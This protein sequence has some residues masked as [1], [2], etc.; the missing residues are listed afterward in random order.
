MIDL[1]GVNTD[2]KF[3]EADAGGGAARERFF[4]LGVCI[5]RSSPVAAR[6]LPAF[7]AAKLSSPAGPDGLAA[8]VR[9]EPGA[10]AES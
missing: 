6:A 8:G 4:E 10:E 1:S 7:F 2:A 3:G 5:S 9:A